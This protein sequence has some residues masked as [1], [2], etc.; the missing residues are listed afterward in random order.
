MEKRQKKIDRRK[1]ETHL[2][3]E[4]LLQALARVKKMHLCEC[5]FVKA[6][7][8]F[9]IQHSQPVLPVEKCWVLLWPFCQGRL[10]I[11][12]KFKAP[13]PLFEGQCAWKGM[14]R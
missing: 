2:C 6:F 11:A 10:T 3:S 5:S 14:S 1:G 13:E 4:E 9:C 7:L 12:E 8:S